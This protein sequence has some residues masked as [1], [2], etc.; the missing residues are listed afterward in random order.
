M[1]TVQARGDLDKLLVL[2][3]DPLLVMIGDRARQAAQFAS[4]AALVRGA[5]TIF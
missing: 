4:S 3:G 5:P 2:L 1:S